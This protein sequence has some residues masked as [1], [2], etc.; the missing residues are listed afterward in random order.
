[1]DRFEYKYRIESLQAQKLEELLESICITD[2]HGNDG[3]YDVLSCYL[4]SS[5]LDAF[6]ENIEGQAYR[7][8][9]RVRSYGG[10]FEN[11]YY[12]IKQRFNQRVIKKRL[13]CAVENIEAFLE[14]ADCPFSKVQEKLWY[15]EMQLM[16]QRLKHQP[17]VYTRYRRKAFLYEGVQPLRFTI[18]YQVQGAKAEKMNFS[19]DVQM[20]MIDL[21][22]PDQAI[23]EVKG[24]KTLPKWFVALVKGLELR[25]GRY[26]KFSEAVKK[27]VLT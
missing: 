22:P 7:K 15:C 5:R 10:Q 9:M 12:E 24:T 26:S 6:Y 1:M 27:C 4:D 3:Q 8:K 2:S 21:L 18:D 14:V 17:I 25:K 16:S 19:D 11:V 13:P 20:D 23:F